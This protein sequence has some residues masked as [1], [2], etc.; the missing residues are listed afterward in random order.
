MCYFQIQTFRKKGH[1]EDNP[2]KLKIQ[3]NYI[4]ELGV[5]KVHAFKLEEISLNGIILPFYRNPLRMPYL[6]VSKG[7][8]PVFENLDLEKE[9]EEFVYNL[10]REDFEKFGYERL[11]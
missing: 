5:S 2:K 8:F 1:R 11:R 9:H 3:N 6:N 10:L 4:D 7:E